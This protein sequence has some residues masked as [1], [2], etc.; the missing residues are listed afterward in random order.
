VKL[1][2]RIGTIFHHRQSIDE[3]P[4]SADRQFSAG[5]ANIQSAA[6]HA[7]DS[8]LSGGSVHALLLMIAML[9]AS[10]AVAEEVSPLRSD[11][12]SG[13]LV[14]VPESL[15]DLLQRG[16][17]PSTL[18]Q[19]VELEKQTR[20]VAKQV[21][22]CTVNVSIGP[23]QGCGVIVTDSGYILTAAHVATRPGKTAIITF[24]D[25]R[26]VK[27]TTL[28][29]NRS[30]DAGMI[31]IDPGQNGSQSWPHAA[32]GTSDNLRPGMWCVATGHPG[33]FDR[34]RGLV[35]RVGRI[36]A[37]RPDALHTDCALIGGDS[38]GPLFDISGR[39]VAIHSRIGNDVTDNLHIPI[40]HYG[41]DWDRLAKAEAWG[42]LPGFRPV[43]GVRGKPDTA[44][45]E[46]AVVA[47]G[48]PAEAAGLQVG[49]VILE[50][51]DV[52][53]TDFQSLRDAVADTM[54]GERL[55]CTIQRGAKRM[56]L[57][58]VEIGRE[59]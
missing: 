24:S 16:G 10:P 58:N 40:D 13:T 4:M 19:M 5:K 45:A 56:R 3:V 25:G 57:N 33:G 39:L 26:I 37:V 44:T 11:R 50:F 55:S 49:D 38:G 18:E 21:A 14:Q 42:Y 31:K 34:N 8:H 28:G 29:L 51:G 52:K 15:D 46:I 1:T 12:S 47:A 6:V 48:S 43:L 9:L 36:L 53:I 32:L 27:G 23:A 41:K 20:R 22:E 7:M 35:T 30:V 17:T 54:P 59:S 2:M